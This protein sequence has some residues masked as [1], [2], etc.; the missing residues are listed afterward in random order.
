MTAIATATAADPAS[1]APPGLPAAGPD[2]RFHAF[3]LDRLVAWSVAGL[4]VLPAV[5]YLA[6]EGRVGT[7]LA[8]AVGGSLLVEA[9]LALLLGLRGTSPGKWALGLRVVRCG[10]GAPIGVGPALLR[11]GVLVAATLPTFGIGV[12]MLAWTAVAD[13]TRQRRGWHDHLAGSVVV[14]VRPPSA[15]VEE[16][17]GGSR[18]IVNLTALRL[19]PAERQPLPAPPAPEREPAA[20]NGGALGSPLRPPPPAGQPAARWRVTVDTGESVPVEGLTL[21]GR[22]PEARPG[23]PVHRLLPLASDDRSLSKT[24]AQLEVADDGVLVVTDRGSTNGSVLLRGGVTR[25][26]PAGRPTT[27]LP[28]DVVRLGDRRLTVAR[29]A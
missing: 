23:E 28:G 3:V 11:A 1:T 17:D 6:L 22:R 14:D 24:H 26:L 9:G 7:G 12:A 5:R 25:A 15:V 18:Q 8:V 29:D 20:R 2:R 13:R 16:D 10:S 27:L 4:A 21:L 19:V